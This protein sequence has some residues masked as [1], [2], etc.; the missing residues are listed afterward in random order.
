MV[1]NSVWAVTFGAF[2]SMR[3]T[4]EGCVSP[5][6]ALMTLRDSRIHVGS[7]DGGYVLTKVER[8]VNK[9]FGLSAVL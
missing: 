9:G 1:F 2:S 4:G 6:P 5:L 7:P 8:A 3:A